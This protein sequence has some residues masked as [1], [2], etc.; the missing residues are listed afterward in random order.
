MVPNLGHFSVMFIIT[1]INS[2]KMPNNNNR[3]L[4]WYL[5]DQFSVPKHCMGRERCFV[6]VILER[7]SD[8]VRCASFPLT[9]VANAEVCTTTNC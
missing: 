5:E 7:I 4:K 8:D 6:V 2:F 3:H 9:P 1:K